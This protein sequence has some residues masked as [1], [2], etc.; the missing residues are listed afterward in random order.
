MH[1]RHNGITVDEN[2]VK[3]L[4]LHTHKLQAKSTCKFGAHDKTLAC[5]GV[6]EY[7]GKK[8]GAIAERGAGNISLSEG[9]F[10]GNGK[11]VIFR[12]F[13]HQEN[14]P[15]EKGSTNRKIERWNHLIRSYG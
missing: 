10:T 6:E 3:Q 13:K 11:T 2:D 12:M 14:G 7:T 15:I 1:D 5:L 9:L 8:C 4:Q